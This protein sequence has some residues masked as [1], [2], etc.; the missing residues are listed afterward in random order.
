M[1]TRLL[2]TFGYE[3]GILTRITAGS[4]FFPFFSI[5]Q[6]HSFHDD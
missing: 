2:L 5:Q 1:C 3:R 6:A 4:K